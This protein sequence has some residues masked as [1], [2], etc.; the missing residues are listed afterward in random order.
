MTDYDAHLF[1]PAEERNQGGGRALYR[2]CLKC[3]GFSLLGSQSAH[4]R[5][6]RPELFKK[7]TDMTPWNKAAVLALLADA[8]FCWLACQTP[9]TIDTL[10]LA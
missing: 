4:L 6:C 8:P 10:A 2:R 3:S 9:A 5:H 1:A 7:D